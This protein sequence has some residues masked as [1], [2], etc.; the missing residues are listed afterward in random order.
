M[1]VLYLSDDVDLYKNPSLPTTTLA[2]VDVRLLYGETDAVPV[3]M[4]PSSLVYKR[5]VPLLF[6]T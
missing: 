6:E 5:A 3:F 4:A 2:A 1:L